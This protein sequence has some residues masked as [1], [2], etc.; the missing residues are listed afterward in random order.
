MQTFNINGS[1]FTCVPLNGKTT[2]QAWAYTIREHLITVGLFKYVN[3]PEAAPDTSVATTVE[4]VALDNAA[5]SHG[6]DEKP[7][8]PPAK[9]T[10]SGELDGAFKLR[11][12]AKSILLSTMR[13]PEVDKIL[14]CTTAA[15]I[16]T[17]FENSYGLKTSNAKLE[18]LKELNSF[19][20]KKASEVAAMTNRIMA[21]KESWSPMIYIWM[22]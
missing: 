13:Q 20:C 15:E 7:T 3:G 16:W 19:S 6:A 5:G 10:K 18:L 14:H 22:I 1:H 21:I 12:E 11:Q 9:A 8:S 4:P 17:H 2:Y